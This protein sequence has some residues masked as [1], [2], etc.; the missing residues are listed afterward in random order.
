MAISIQLCS[1][2]FCHYCVGAGNDLMFKKIHMLGRVLLFMTDQTSTSRLILIHNVLMDF[3]RIYWK[4]DRNASG[5]QPTTTMMPLDVGMPG[6]RFGASIM[7]KNSL[8]Y[9]CREST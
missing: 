1:I 6:S 9:H 3:V 2:E 5:V 8:E 7:V 4:S